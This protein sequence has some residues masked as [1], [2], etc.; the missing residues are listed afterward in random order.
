MVITVEEYAKKFPSKGK[1][2]SSKTIVRRC[3]NG[4]LPSHHKARKLP[5]GDWVI[6]IADET[7]PEIIVT[8]TSPV[9]PFFKKMNQKYFNIR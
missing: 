1:F 2:L 9:Q 8:K 4:F 5:G 6:E 7:P 3:I